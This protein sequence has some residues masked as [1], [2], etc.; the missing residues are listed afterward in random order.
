MTLDLM[1]V[2]FCFR[3]HCKYKHIWTCALPGWI[4]WIKYKVTQGY[5][6]RSKYPYDYSVSF[7]RFRGFAI[8]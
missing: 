1:H 8:L 3:L 5:D 7:L 4:A 6:Y 2:F